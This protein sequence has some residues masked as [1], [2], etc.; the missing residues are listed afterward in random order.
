MR[1][2]ILRRSKAEYYEFGV[3]YYAAVGGIL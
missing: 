3:L 2:V 1:R